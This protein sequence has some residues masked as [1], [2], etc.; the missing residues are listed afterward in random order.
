MR[1]IAF[2][3]ALGEPREVDAEYRALGYWLRRLF[4]LPAAPTRVTYFGS[5]T[6]WHNADTGARASLGVEEVLC[7]AWA[8]EC[9]RRMP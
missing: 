9:Y 5:G 4:R 8:L 1:V 2:R 3:P 6:V 7:D